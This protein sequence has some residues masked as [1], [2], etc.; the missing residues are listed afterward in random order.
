MSEYKRLTFKK[1]GYCQSDC[2]GKDICSAQSKKTCHIR[3]LYNRLAELEDKIENEQTYANYA[4][5]KV[6]DMDKLSEEELHKTVEHIKTATY[7][8]PNTIRELQKVLKYHCDYLEKLAML[9]SSEKENAWYAGQKC[10]FDNVLE[11]VE[12]IIALKAI[13]ED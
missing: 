5:Y 6:E 4:R 1:D 2:F 8:K 13:N 9:G 11:W 10:A 7:T 3:K 12:R